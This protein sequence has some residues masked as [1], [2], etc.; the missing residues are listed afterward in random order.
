MRCWRTAWVFNELLLGDRGC[1]STARVEYE[2][3]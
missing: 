3:Y 1:R 2:D